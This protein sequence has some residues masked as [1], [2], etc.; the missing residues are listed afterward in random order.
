VRLP[1]PPTFEQVQEACRA[2][3]LEPSETLSFK[4]GRHE[5]AYEVKHRN[6]AGNTVGVV[7]AVYPFPRKPQSA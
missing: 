2:L 5:I 6:D 7:T 1:K 3:G 4:V